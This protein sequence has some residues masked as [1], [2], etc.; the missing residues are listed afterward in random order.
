M[1]I[2]I[3]RRQ[4]KLTHNLFNFFFFFFEHL[5]LQGFFFS[6]K[7][8]TKSNIIRSFIS[9][10]NKKKKRSQRT[11]GREYCFFFFFLFW[12]FSHK[13]RG[14]FPIC[15]TEAYT[16]FAT[17][18]VRRGLGNKG[19]ILWIFIFPCIGINR[20]NKHCG[21]SALGFPHSEYCLRL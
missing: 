12:L 19:G 2:T 11:N 21:F 7:C 3:S 5:R 10:T 18:G 15:F 8:I 4:P 1:A 20:K 9:C 14:V 17:L 16:I 13:G 6:L